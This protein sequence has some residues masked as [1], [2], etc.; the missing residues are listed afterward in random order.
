MPRPVVPVVSV[1][2]TA[3]VKTRRNQQSIAAIFNSFIRRGKILRDTG[4]GN[5]KLSLSDSDIPAT[6]TRDSELTAAI[7]ALLEVHPTAVADYT[8]TVNSSSTDGTED[9][10]YSTTLTAGLLGTNGDKIEANY[11]G[12][13][14]NHA[15]ATRRLKAYFGGTAIFD[16]G[17]ITVSATVAWVLRV[18]YIRVSSS[19]IRHCTVFASE[20]ISVNPMTTVGELTGLTLANTNVVKITAAATGVGAAASDISSYMGSLVK[21]PNA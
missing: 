16:T 5:W 13:W 1:D 7:A 3:P 11:A 6:I 8:T 21:V 15:T 14:V 20:G 4:R 19:V 2:P 17:A 12:S 10:L 9:D 18:S